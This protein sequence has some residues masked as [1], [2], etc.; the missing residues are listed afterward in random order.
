MDTSIEDRQVNLIIL[1]ENANYQTLIKDSFLH[2]IL[3]LVFR[4]WD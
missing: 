3:Q 2:A 1:N 4:K